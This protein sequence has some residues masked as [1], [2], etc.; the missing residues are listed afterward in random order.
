M[1]YPDIIVYSADLTELLEILESKALD[2]H[3]TSPF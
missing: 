1:N 2:R 3:T